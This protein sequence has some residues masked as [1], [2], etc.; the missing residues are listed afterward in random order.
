MLWHIF[1]GSPHQIQSTL[2]ICNPSPRISSPILPKIHLTTPSVKP[3]CPNIPLHCLVDVLQRQPPK[4]A[5]QHP[6]LHAASSTFKCVSQTSPSMH[7]HFETWISILSTQNNPLKPPSH[8]PTNDLSP[9]PCTI[10]IKG[11]F[12][13]VVITTNTLSG[14]NLHDNHSKILPRT[15]PTHSHHRSLTIS[16]NCNTPLRYASSMLSSQHILLST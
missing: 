13:Y 16:P 1:Y 14:P 4:V 5:H 10:P 2:I 9:I 3:P 7:T 11:C 15:T 12:L 8:N 6:C